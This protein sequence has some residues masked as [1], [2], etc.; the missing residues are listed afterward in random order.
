MVPLPVFVPVVVDSAA[1]GMAVHVGMPSAVGVLVLVLVKHNLELPAERLGDAAQGLEAWHV[2][3]AFEPRNHRLGHP[4]PGRELLLRL[5]GTAAQ[6]EQLAG[7]LP[8]NRR[9]VVDRRL[10]SQLGAFANLL[11]PG[12]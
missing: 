7:A 2:V 12:T 1:T 5:T 8:G 3:A 9:A 4:E 6:F 11:R 10:S